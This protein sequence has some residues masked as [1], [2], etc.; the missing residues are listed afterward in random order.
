MNTSNPRSRAVDPPTNIEL[1]SRPCVKHAAHAATLR[2]LP[3]CLHRSK[4]LSSSSSGQ[5]PDS[6]CSGQQIRTLTCHT[7]AGAHRLRRG[8]QEEGVA[9]VFTHPG[10]KKATRMSN[11][12]EQ[13]CIENTSTWL[14]ISK[15]THTHTPQKKHEDLYVNLCMHI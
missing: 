6:I 2:Y 9:Q 3:A 10:S 13:D 11:V 4:D 12:V 5:K 1:P 8:R 7:E 15:S 14:Y